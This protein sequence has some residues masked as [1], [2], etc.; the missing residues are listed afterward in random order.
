MSTHTIYRDGVPAGT[1]A[2][3]DDVLLGA[4][5]VAAYLGQH[6]PGAQMFGL[7]LVDGLEKLRRH[8]I[9]EQAYAHMLE[10]ALAAERA[11]SK[12]LAA[13]LGEDQ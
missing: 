2:I 10:K 6:P 8:L 3:P 9:H 5:K 12:T 1:I 4:Q 7:T 11:Y 13:K